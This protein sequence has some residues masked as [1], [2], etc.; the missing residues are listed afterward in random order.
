MWWRQVLFAL[1]LTDP[2]P[3]PPS[4][5]GSPPT[6]LVFS[7]LSKRKLVIGLKD[8]PANPGRSRLKVLNLIAP[9]L[10][11]FPNKVTF[12]CSSVGVWLG[13]SEFTSPCCS[14]GISLV[15][16]D[17]KDLFMSLLVTLHQRFILEKPSGIAQAKWEV[18]SGHSGIE[19][20][21]EA[22][23]ASMRHVWCPAYSLL[24][25]DPRV[26]GGGKIFI[27]LKRIHLCLMYNTIPITQNILSKHLSRYW[28]H[29]IGREW[30]GRVSLVPK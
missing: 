6:P 25:L 17:V 28:T 5:P 26:C 23:G 1:R 12:T 30:L 13:L 7:S 14:V 10:T 16:D 21:T 4:S 2:K 11:V 19:G 20:D 29:F 15:T 27:L 18:G 3:W 24:Y 22:R 9:A 8:Q